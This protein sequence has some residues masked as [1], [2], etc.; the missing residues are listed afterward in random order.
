FGM[1]RSHAEGVVMG[2]Y[3]LSSWG[4]RC[5]T[6]APLLV[7]CPVRGPIAAELVQIPP[8]EQPGVMPVI[9][10]N[11]DCIL[12]DRLNRP[13]T[14]VFLAEHQDFLSGAVPFHFGGRRVN[15]QILECEL[16]PAAVHKTD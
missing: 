16:K 6:G 8:G 11:F 1:N 3:S 15:A 2:M 7:P 10:D 9:E 13:D 14:H 4:T 12:P 5:R